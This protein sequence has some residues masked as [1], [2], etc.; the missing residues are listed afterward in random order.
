[1][2]FVGK[3]LG[4]IKEA[5]EGGTAYLR[6]KNGEST[7]IRILTPLDEIVSIY[8]HTEQIDGR[9]RNFTCLGRENCPLCKADKRASFKSFIVVYD[10]KDEKVKIFKA[11]KTVGK[12]LIAL[13][14]EYGDLTKRDMKIKREGDGLQTVYHFFVRDE[15]GFEVE[16]LELP[17]VD[18]LVAPKT[19]E[20]ISEMMGGGAR[21]VVMDEVEDGDLPF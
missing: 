6:L 14:E 3:G 20:E 10:Y 15:K 11:S 4:A 7:T 9:W 21:E 5:N 13:V 18:E 1:M 2:S 19:P 17:D 16:G 8:E 12:D